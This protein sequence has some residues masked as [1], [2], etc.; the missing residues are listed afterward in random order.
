MM[1]ASAVCAVAAICGIA[2]LTLRAYVNE[3]NYDGLFVQGCDIFGYSEMAQAFREAFVET[4]RNF[5]KKDLDAS[6]VRQAVVAAVSIRVARLG[7]LSASAGAVRANARIAS[8]SQQR[9]TASAAA[10]IAACQPSP[11]GSTSP[12]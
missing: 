12:R 4:L 6:D 9:V 10:S 11:P 7:L 3:R 2:A 5:Y 8:R 1:L